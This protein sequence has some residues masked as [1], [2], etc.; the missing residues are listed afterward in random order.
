M[1]H[2]SISL[3]RRCKKAEATIGPTQRRVVRT[4]DPRKTEK[5]SGHT[6]LPV[7]LQLSSRF[8]PPACYQSEVCPP[9]TVQIYHHS[10][11]H[12]QQCWGWLL[13]IAAVT[14]VVA[15]PCTLL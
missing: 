15:A 13:G 11:R 2:F 8:L 5:K 14:S 9:S 12:Y 10:D 3:E 4:H 6:V 7:L 1:E